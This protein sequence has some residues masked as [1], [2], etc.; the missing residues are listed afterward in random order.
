MACF[1]FRPVLFFTH[2]P[3]TVAAS[4]CCCS[5]GPLLLHWLS[6]VASLSLSALGRVQKFNPYESWPLFQFLR[7]SKRWSGYLTHT[8]INHL[9]SRLYISEDSVQLFN[10]ITKIIM[11]AN[12]QEQTERDRAIVKNPKCR[13]GGGNQR[14]FQVIFIIVLI[15]QNKFQFHF[16]QH[17][18]R[19]NIGIKSTSRGSDTKSCS[20]RRHR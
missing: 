14:R 5:G 12:T 13:L 19:D 8:Y 3:A 11:K 9:I 18:R 15:N 1:V 2:T 10:V 17:S 7:S 20:V 16:S 6:V 4:C